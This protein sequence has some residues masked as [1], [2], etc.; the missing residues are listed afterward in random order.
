M[1]FVQGTEDDSV[2]VSKFYAHR[3]YLNF[4]PK[5]S[6][7]LSARMTPDITIDNIGDVKVRLKYLYMN[8][9]LQSRS[10]FTK[11]FVEFGLV[12]RVW[13]DFEEH[14]NLYR[15]QGTMFLERNHLFNSADFGVT[16]VSLF[17]GEVDESYQDEVSSK[18]PG[19]Y[20]SMAVGIYNGGGYHAK[21][22]NTN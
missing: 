8:F 1:S 16:F 7:T 2:D 6:P 14:V 17:G 22:N 15:M 4:K 9:N 13:L 5:F 19:R 10:I 12:H 18:Y 11:P 3:G 21:E 20:G